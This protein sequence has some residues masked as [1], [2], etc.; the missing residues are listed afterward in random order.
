MAHGRVL[1]V[2]FLLPL[3]D[4]FAPPAKLLDGDRSIDDALIDLHLEQTIKEGIRYGVLEAMDGRSVEIV[5]KAGFLH[6]LEID[7][8]I[9]EQQLV[10]LLTV[11]TPNQLKLL[12]EVMLE[13][14]GYLAAPGIIPR[15]LEGLKKEQQ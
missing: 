4:D 13:V 7:I 5:L 9:N 15:L 1:S 8:T 12:G 11:R 14:E 10:E 6:F 2:L 3:V